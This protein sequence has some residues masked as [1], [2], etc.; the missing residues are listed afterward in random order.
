ML[1]DDDQTRLDKIICFYEWMRTHDT[2][3]QRS[4]D[5]LRTVFQRALVVTEQ[6]FSSQAVLKYALSWRQTAAPSCSDV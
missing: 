2:S 6:V 3:V 1:K 5:G 4:H